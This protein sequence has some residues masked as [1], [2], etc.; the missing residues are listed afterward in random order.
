MNSTSCN[1]LI[2]SYQ[3]DPPEDNNN[4]FWLLPL[5]SYP[6]M[7][8]SLQ[9]HGPQHTRPLCP[10]PSPE[11]CPS[12]CPLHQW[13]HPAISSS[14]A[15]FSC[16]QP[17]LASRTCPKSQLFASDDQNTGHLDKVLKKPNYLK[18]LRNNQEKVHCGARWEK[19]PVI[20]PERPCMLLI[21]LQCRRPRFNLWV[22]KIPW[23]RAWQPTL[24]LLPGESHGQ[25]SLQGYSPW[26]HTEWDMTEAS[27]QQQQLG[28]KAQTAHNPGH[29]SGMNLQ[30]EIL[31]DYIWSPWGTKSGR[32]N[33]W[34]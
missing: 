29:Y 20:N 8:D 34:M 22:G 9:P 12:S 21:R 31:K 18:A 14:D 15:L 5:F 30:W 2:S 13:C 28:R 24:V 26:G 4:K 10:S 16:P 6:V 3:D 7:S 33:C 27:M 1:R 32:V 17:F 19:S 23:R 11:V 25:R